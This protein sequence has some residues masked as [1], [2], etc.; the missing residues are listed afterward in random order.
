MYPKPYVIY[1]ATSPKIKIPVTNRCG[2]GWNPPLRI[3]IT[4]CSK[5]SS[6]SNTNTKSST[7]LDENCAM[8]HVVDA[9]RE[10]ISLLK[11]EKEAY[12]LL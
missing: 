2:M 8:T 10:P 1:L 11:D 7:S 9:A 4:A 6:A 5:L 12:A 3:P